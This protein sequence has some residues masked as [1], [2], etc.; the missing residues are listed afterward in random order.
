MTASTL[1]ESQ[2]PNIT[3]PLASLYEFNILFSSGTETPGEKARQRAVNYGLSDCH[4]RSVCWRYF[5]GVVKGPPGQGWIEQ[6]ARHRAYFEKQKTALLVDP[7]RLESVDL[8]VDNP[9]SSESGS[10]WNQYFE[11]K[12]AE[13][14]ILMDINR[15]FPEY[16]FFHR[17]TIVQLLDEVLVIWARAHP[18]HGY[19]QGMHELLGALYYV[20]AHDQSFDPTLSDQ[21]ENFQTRQLI[22][23]ICDPN[24]L[25]HDLYTAFNFLIFK[26]RNWYFD[27]APANQPRVSEVVSELE[28]RVPTI[29]KESRRIFA[30]LERI[31][32]EIANFLSNREIEPHLF[33]MK[34]LRVLYLRV[35]SLDQTMRLWDGIFAVGPQLELAEWVAVSMIRSIKQQL[36][37]SDDL[38]TIR[39]LMDFPASSDSSAYIIEAYKLRF[40]GVPLPPFIYLVDVPEEFKSHTSPISSHSPA[41]S[42]PDSISLRPNQSPNITS[43]P[44]ILSSS[45]KKPATPPTSSSSGEKSLTA[46]FNTVVDSIPNTSLNTAPAPPPR[47]PVQTVK[48]KPVRA[49]PTWIPTRISNVSASSDTNPPPNSLR[50]SQPTP[51]TPLRFT[52][53]PS[54]KPKTKLAAQKDYASEA[55]ERLTNTL[56]V[57]VRTPAVSSLQRAIRDMSEA[58]QRQALKLVGVMRAMAQA[59]DS[60]GESAAPLKSMLGACFGEIATVVED[61]WSGERTTIGFPYV[62]DA[63]TV[64]DGEDDGGAAALLSEIEVLERGVNAYTMPDDQQRDRVESVIEKGVTELL[65]LTVPVSARK[66]QT[67]LFT[68]SEAADSPQASAEQASYVPFVSTVGTFLTPNTATTRTIQRTLNTIFISP[69]PPST[70]PLIEPDSDAVHPPTQIALSSTPPLPTTALQ[71]PASSHP[72]P[73]PTMTP[74]PLYQVNSY[75]QNAETDMKTLCVP[76]QTRAGEV[77]PLS[78]LVHDENDTQPLEQQF[79]LT[80]HPSSRTAPLFDGDD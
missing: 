39:L 66:A 69:L 78:E 65:S 2:S 15:L 7:T 36:L 31:D 74:P 43:S 52:K 34:W 18:Q 54:E 35:F 16:P 32:P 67:A 19:K 44:N 55:I 13:A 48:P 79:V 49:P 3:S 8:S 14:Q 50:P 29:V 40:P 80:G 41:A 56:L 28:G 64:R 30:H 21:E 27:D 75:T 26:L 12:Q 11:T 53:L 47:P 10:Q 38:T 6:L 33:L 62:K 58:N 1:S 60:A 77:I 46:F 59:V 71:S 9:L 20:F 61:L 76:N 24:Y 4:I 45:Y 23:I 57:D 73:L 5:L 25:E 51:Q 72:S 37:A 42:T 68:D 70:Q 22:N 17:E 63:I